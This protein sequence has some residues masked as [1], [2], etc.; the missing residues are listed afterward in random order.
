MTPAGRLG[1]VRGR[2]DI[3]LPLH[4]G[5]LVATFDELW[6]DSRMVE[7]VPVLSPGGL[8]RWKIAVGREKDRRDTS[9]IFEWLKQRSPMYSGI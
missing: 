5:R 8:L 1:Q 3:M 6:S 2:L 7:G 9:L 4:E